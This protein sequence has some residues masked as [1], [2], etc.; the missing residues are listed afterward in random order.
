MV[1]WRRNHEKELP[2]S[3]RIFA[4][5]EYELSENILKFFASKGLLKKQL[6]L[7][8]QIPVFEITAVESYWNELS[9]T[10]NGI[11]NLFFMKNSFESFSNLRDQIKDMLEQRR[12]DLEFRGKADVRRADLTSVME[13]SIRIVDISFDILMGLREKR[14]NWKQFESYSSR[15]EAGLNLTPPTLA[16]LNL[17]F[18][19]VARAIIRQVRN[20]ISD[21]VF[22]VLKTIYGYFDSLKLEDDLIEAHPNFKDTKA[23]MT[24]YYALN[25]LLLGKAIGEID[26]EKERLSLESILQEIASET[27]FKVNVEG[28]NA[29]IDIVGVGTDTHDVVEQSRAIFREQLVQLQK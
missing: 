4:V 11:T 9:L 15:L 28:L 10:W 8:R 23:L 21:E 3:R 16:Q 1:N 26:N 29:T 13:A 7:I 27:N 24:A 14:V 2:F 12:K 18:S 19:G 20:E 5:S 22:N 6:V 17:D 25:D